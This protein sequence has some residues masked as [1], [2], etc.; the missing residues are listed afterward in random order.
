M[1]I[2]SEKALVQLQEQLDKNRRLVDV[3]HFDLPVRELV[4]MTSE[5]ELNRAPEYQRRFR[6]DSE[7]KS[8]LIESLFLGLPVP[9]IYVATN[10]DGSWELIDGLQRVSTIVQFMAEDPEVLETVGTKEPLRLSHLEKLTKFNGFAYQELPTSLQ[11]TLGKRM[12]RVVSLSDKSDPEIR[13]EMFERL[14]TGGIMLTPQEVRACIFRGDAYNK[15]KE[16]AKLDSLR[17]LLKLQKLHAEDGTREEQVLKFFAY[18][19]HRDRYDGDVKLFLNDF[20]KD[21]C[22]YDVSRLKEISRIFEKASDSLYKIT[23]GPFL[24]QGY[25]N[26]PLNQF[27]ACLVAVAEIQMAQRS[28]KTPKSDWL[29]DPELLKHS[30]KGT[31]TN[32]ALS[33]RINRAKTLLGG[34]K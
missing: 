10:K 7:K 15:I 4:R 24:R 8:R 20:M 31:N 19:L 34:E 22:E 12:I 26:T 6:W 5:S 13:Y 33:G 30:T 18:L 21:M 25:G 3:E 16:L 29:N 23:K 9:S 27:E 11:W 2:K 1:H 32:A 28:V 17:K 14:N